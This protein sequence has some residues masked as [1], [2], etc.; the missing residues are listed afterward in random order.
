MMPVAHHTPL[1]WPCTG[2]DQGVRLGVLD[3][4]WCHRRGISAKKNSKPHHTV[5]FQDLNKHALPETH[6]T[7]SPFRQARQVPSGKVKTVFDARNGY[8]S[9]PLHEADRHKTTFIT[10]WGRYRYLSAP[11]GYITSGDGYSRRY[12]KV[13]A[14]IGKKTKWTTHCCGLTTSS[15]PTFKRYNDSTSAAGTAVDFAGFTITMTDVWPCSRYLEAIRDFPQLRNV[16]NV[17]SWFSMVNQVAYTFSMAEHMQPFRRLLQSGVR[18]EWSP[19]LESVFHES[20][21][22]I[23]REIDYGVRIFDKSKPTCLAT[24]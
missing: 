24:D 4:V 21:E 1:H 11:Q 9:V 10:L 5:D 14:D 23:I 19:E 15:R 6:H 12:D 7:Q 8:H 2:L 16:T 13:V 22:T 17:R 18:F 3:E 20:K